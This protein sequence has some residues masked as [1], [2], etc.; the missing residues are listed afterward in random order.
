MAE[1]KAFHNRPPAWNLSE[2]KTNDYCLQAASSETHGFATQ[3]AASALPALGLGFRL[4]TVSNTSKSNSTP[5]I[6]A[7]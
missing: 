3:E 7:S 2:G 1:Q 6:E 5:W 4:R